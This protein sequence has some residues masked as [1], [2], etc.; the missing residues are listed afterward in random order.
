MMP[1]ITMS[2]WRLIAGVAVGL[3]CWVAPAS[4]ILIES[5]DAKNTQVGG[6]LIRDDGANLTIRIRTPDG[7]EQDVTYALDKIKILH[8]LDVKRLEALSRDN[9]KGYRDYAAELAQQK[10]DPEARDTAIRLF[11]IAAKLAPE[12]FGSSSL[13]SMSELASTPTEAHKYRA[14]AFVLDP[15]AG[16][17]LLKAE[18][19]KP[20]PLDRNQ[21]RALDDF[22]KALQH[23]RAGR[24]KLATDTVRKDGVD[25]IFGLAPTKLDQKTF[26]QWCTDANCENCRA[27]GTV[28]CPNCKG[29]RI[30]VG[31]FGQRERCSTCNGNGRLICPDC[32]GTHVRDPLPEQSVRGALRLELWAMEQQ[33]LGGDPGRKEATEP[34]GWSTVL[35]SRRLSPVLPLSL[36]TIT[37][38]DPRKCRYRNGKW[39]DE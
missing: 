8:R 33:G 2:V 29:N 10:K 24:L 11:L 36:D 17:E 1:R 28:V 16:P 18:A 30:V 31:M 7:R 35:Q 6:F 14:L 39:V 9:P 5:N 27:D 4:A 22:T 26:L 19:V 32:G 3:F 25:K 38:F 15:K 34:K 23:Y 20:P 37:D 13:L 21:L 12:K